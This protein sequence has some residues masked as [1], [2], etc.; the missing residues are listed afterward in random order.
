MQNILPLPQRKKF[1]FLNISLNGINR[2]LFKDVFRT[3]NKGTHTET[4]RCPSTFILWAWCLR[5]RLKH[6]LVRFSIAS[7]LPAAP[8]EFLDLC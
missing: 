4:F 2:L 5:G 7:S 3:D 1:T 8:E 6:A